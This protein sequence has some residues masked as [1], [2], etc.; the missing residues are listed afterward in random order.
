M[1]KPSYLEREHDWQT[2]FL[3]E[4]RRLGT[5]RPWGRAL[6]AV[7]WIHLGFFLICQA[8]YSS[9]ERG[10]W[11]SLVL[12]SLEVGTVVLAMKWIAGKGW[13]YES[14]I[15]RLVFR[16]WVTFLILSFNVATLNTL[17]G[18]EVDW[19]KV[20]WCTLG[21]FGFATSAWLFGL[22]FLIPA[23]QM[24]FTGLIMVR[25][26]QWNYV[27]HG[28]SWCVALQFVGWDMTRRCRRPIL[29][30]LPNSAF[31]RTIPIE[32]TARE[33]NASILTSA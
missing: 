29:L 23:F 12:W 14:S 25:Y 9:G 22:R 33:G 11:P 31:S 19:F 20:V 6:M 2:P 28:I 24:Y 32:T 26:P 1:E 17:T 27:I 4:L 5:L 18:F 3:E 10:K 13:L 8:V 15:V 7:G 16:I 21:S 30:E